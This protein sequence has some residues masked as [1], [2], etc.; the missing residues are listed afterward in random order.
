[1]YGETSATRI[2]HSHVPAS[3][4]AQSCAFW[5]YMNEPFVGVS[6]EEFGCLVGGEVIHNDNIILEVSLLRQRAINRVAYRFLA[7]AHGN[8]HRRLEVEVLFVEVG[9]RISTRIHQCSYLA[10][11][12]CYGTFHLYLHLA[13]G[14][15]D[16]VELLHAARSE[17][18]LMLGI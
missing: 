5:H 13:V 11:M 14:W 10:Q 8:N 15:V 3:S 18:F 2:V 16:I 1:M 4:D 12:L 6:I 9:H 7:I 17:V